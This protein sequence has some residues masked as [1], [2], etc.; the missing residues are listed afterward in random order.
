MPYD[1][2]RDLE[3]TLDFVIDLNLAE[4]MEIYPLSL[5]PGTQLRDEAQSMGITYMPHPPYWVLSTQNMSQKDLKFAVEMMENKLGIEFFPPIIP[6]FKNIHPSYLHFL[7]LREKEGLN[8]QLNVLYR[9][10]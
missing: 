4:S 6:R 5:I 8:C 7:D 10:F 3:H 1:V 9:G 2:L